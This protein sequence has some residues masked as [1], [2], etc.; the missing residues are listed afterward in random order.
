MTLTMV[1]RLS[2]CLLLAYRVEAG[3]VRALVPPG[4]ELVTCAGH[5][6]WNVVACRVERM[7]P[8][9][10]PKVLGL[11]Y[12]HVAYRLYVRATSC[13]VD[14]LYFVRSDADS[15]LISVAGNLM[16]DFRF[17]P[18][19]I[20]LSAD[21]PRVNCTVRG[22]SADAD[23]MVDNDSPPPSLATNSP[24][25]SPEEAARFLKYRPV[26]MS[27]SRRGWLKLTTVHRH[28]PDWHERRVR[29]V[30]D[31]LPFLD[32]FGPRHLELATRVEPLDY[33]WVLGKPV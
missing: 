23:V 1:G 4:L 13:R 16:T 9:G 24:F 31:H 5:A 25:G 30:K 2:E 19:T 3:A 29:V 26:A 27:V 11:S 28:E 22:H 12:N 18:S 6:F 15:R 33:R 7:R 8:P 21:G 17:H 10:L 20:T 32:R 14:G